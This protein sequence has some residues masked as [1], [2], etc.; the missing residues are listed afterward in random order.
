VRLQEA[1]KPHR[2]PPA[3]KLRPQPTIDA[4]SAPRPLSGF[5]EVPQPGKTATEEIFQASPGVVGAEREHFEAKQIA[6]V[7][8]CALARP[9]RCPVAGPSGALDW[10]ILL[11]YKPRLAG[12]L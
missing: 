8:V 10:P 3:A 1:R 6:L 5:R 11:H 7:A 9:A 12:W 2:V 4:R